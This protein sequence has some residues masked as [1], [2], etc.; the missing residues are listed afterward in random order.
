MLELFDSICSAHFRT[1]YGQLLEPQRGNSH[2]SSKRWQL[3]PTILSCP[4]SMRACANDQTRRDKRLR[5]HGCVS[6]TMRMCGSRLRRRATTLLVPSAD[7][8]TSR[9]NARVRLP[10]YISRLS[11]QLFVRQRCTEST[12]R[13]GLACFFVAAS[14]IRSFAAP[15][16]MNF[17]I[18][19][20]SSTW[21]RDQPL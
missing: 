20:A 19:P 12:H 9:A 14:S 16:S 18:P 8:I 11:R 2:S 17:V 4:E 15:E 7:M 1:W 13:T 6:S 5:M 21:F 10:Y 3:T